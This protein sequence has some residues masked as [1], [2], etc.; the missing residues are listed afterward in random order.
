LT[1][2]RGRKTRARRIEGARGGQGSAATLAGEP[3]SFAGHE[4]DGGRE[5]GPETRR[6]AE[7]VVRAASAELLN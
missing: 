1:C 6:K 3:R 4:A 7:E 5:A 2:P